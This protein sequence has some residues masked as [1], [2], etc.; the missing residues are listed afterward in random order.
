[1][2]EELWT[3]G[4]TELA[5]RIRERQVSSREVV[6]AHLAR[7]E[8]VNS[9]LNAVVVVLAESALEVEASQSRRESCQRK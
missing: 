9:Q 3:L 2:S 4:V 7:I 6:E 5:T 8:A 1:M